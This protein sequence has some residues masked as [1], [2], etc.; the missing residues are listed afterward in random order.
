MVYFTAI[1]ER[2]D[3]SA[4]IFASSSMFSPGLELLGKDTVILTVFL[5]TD[6][7]AAAPCSSSSL[8]FVTNR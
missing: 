5:E 1:T 3:G 6:A 7:I 8:R 2:G 4:V